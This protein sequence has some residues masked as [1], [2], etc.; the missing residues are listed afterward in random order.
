MKL[1]KSIK[2]CN[3]G[4]ILST[5]LV[6][7]RCASCAGYWFLIAAL[8]EINGFNYDNVLN[9]AKHNVRNIIIPRKTAQIRINR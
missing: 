4:R 2:R 9:E 3:C 8:R 5:K 6:C 1:G 7:N